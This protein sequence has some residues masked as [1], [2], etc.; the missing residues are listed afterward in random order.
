MF[1]PLIFGVL[2]KAHQSTK[3]SLELRGVRM[4]NAAPII[5]KSLG[6]D[7][8]S[9]GPTLKNDVILLRAKD[10]D[11]EEL[12]ANFAKVLNATWEKRGDEW[13]FTQ[14]TEQK[15]ED[16]RTYDKNRYQFFR[17]MVD[18]AKKKIAGLK[19]LDEAE[20]KRLVKEI[21]DISTMQLN[22]SNNAIW[23]KTSKIDEQGP[24]TRLG[25][26]A[27][28]RITPEVWMKLTEQNPRVVFSTRPNSM[29]QPFPFRIDDLLGQT[30]DE[31]NQWSTYAS[32]EPLRGPSVGDDEFS[33]Y[34]LGSLNEHRQPFK[35][36]D[37][38][39]VTMT[40]ELKNQSIEFNAYD[41]KGKSTLNTNVSFY[42]Y[43]D[44]G[45]YRAEYEKVK[46]KMVK[47]S[48]DAGEYLD[49]VAPM[50]MYG[51][52]NNFYQKISPSLL[53][54][55]L[56]PEKIDPLSIAAP[57][58]ILPSIESPNVIIVMSYYE[59]A[60]RYVDF[61]KSRYSQVTGKVL[62]DKDGW[63]LLSQPDPVAARK[64]MPDRQR[65]GNL[66]RFVNENKRPLTIEERASL[67]FALPWET[68]ASYLYESHLKLLYTNAVDSY[69]NRTG[70]R[71]Y[72]ALN[73][74]ER[75]TAKKG[76]IPLSR[77]SDEAKLDIYRALF[78]SQ[79]YE[80]QVE[81]DWAN[82]G[83]M[84]PTHAAVALRRHI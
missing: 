16:Q 1:V 8:I 46:K 48:G 24:T 6:L 67:E 45:D 30:M 27:A 76:G 78:Y 65:L 80:S 83:N 41:Q 21:K 69:N 28:L 59:R 70:L 79:K 36:T 5:A 66:L 49:L 74:T 13:W 73:S 15:I 38:Y 31:Q 55:M 84:T 18:K 62:S 81:M 58:V 2:V 4:E 82:M 64:L 25:Y 11:P 33:N 37:F 50:N 35:S 17:D 19:P 54:K 10:V 68:E 63:F 40:L 47:L 22:R 51:Y 53:A 52:Q 9:I 71:I 61:K 20:C 39:N 60:A 32:G 72:G 29:Q 43:A 34:W 42:D 56:Q 12:K 75:E 23:Q 26:R 7:S 44:Q 57:D 14:T 3:V 77:L